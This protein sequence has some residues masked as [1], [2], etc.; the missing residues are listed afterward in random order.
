MADRK[1]I[2][3]G[4]GLGGL[5]HGILLKKAQPDED[6][7]IYDLN[8]IPGGFCTAFKKAATYNNEKLVYTVNIPLITSDFLENEPLG[9]FLKY[10]GV[11]NLDWRVVDNLFKFYPLDDEPFLFKKGGEQEFIN[12]A[13]DPAERKRLEKFFKK[14][15]DFYNELFHKG[16]VNPRP[17]QAIKLLLT[18]PKTILTL[19]NDKTY[20]KLIE[21]IGIKSKTVKEILCSAEAFMGVEADEVSG[22]GEMCMIQSFLENNAVQPDNGQTFQTLSDRLADRFKE[23]GGK[24]VLNTPVESV[25]FDNKKAVGV[26]ING[27][28]IKADTVILSVAQDKIKPLIKE[29]SHIGN[30]KRLIKK[31][32]KLPYPNSDYYCY[33][34]VEKDVI[35][36][37]PKF[38]DTAYHIYRLPEGVDDNWKM[39]IWVPNELVNG[40]Y[41]VLSMVMTE[42]DQ[43]K[44]DWWM[45]LREK[46][47]ASYQIEKEKVADKYLKLLQDVEPVFKENPPLKTLM[48]FSPASYLPYGSKYP[49]SGLAQVP[50]NF[51]ANRMAPEI[52]DNLFISSGSNFSCGVWGAMSG[53]WQGFVA[54][55]EKIYGVRIGDHDILYTEK[56]NN[57]P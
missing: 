6:V 3:I 27:E 36:K 49:I 41:Y 30:V 20:L 33:Y 26:R 7:T 37:N 21:S 2:I 34:L 12:R 19:M 57:L 50:D 18:I 56:L 9:D 35:E 11:K 29:G 54:S 31:I 23:L 53:G 51:G 4:A 22:V 38:L 14:M 32:E 46:D 45:D 28:E 10:L 1:T 47:Y 16:K 55:Y 13:K 44:I 25:V 8:K 43:K 40:K 52:T 39:P 17:L 48:V 24:L 5:V 42:K 15:K